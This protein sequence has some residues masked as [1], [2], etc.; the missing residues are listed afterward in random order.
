MEKQFTILSE[1]EL[2]MLAHQLL[3]GYASTRVFIFTGN[4]GA[5]KTTFVKQICAFLGVEGTMSSPSFSIVNE[6]QTNKGEPVYH[7]DCYRMKDESEAWDIGLDEILDSGAYCFIE[8]PDKID[9]LLPENYVRVSIT[10]EENQRI[11][12]F[13]KEI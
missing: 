7:V 4:L 6:Y 8:W 10:Q 11:F 2:P 9:N 13:S 3:D 5:G 1:S 12:K